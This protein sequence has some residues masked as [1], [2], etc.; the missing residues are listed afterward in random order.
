LAKARGIPV[1]NHYSSQKIKRNQSICREMTAKHAESLIE[2]HFSL[3]IIEL[4]SL[5]YVWQMNI[6]QAAGVVCSAGSP[7]LRN[8]LFA[9]WFCVWASKGTRQYQLIG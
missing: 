1:E 8:Q 4:N 6:V 3:K 9:G 2:N 5:K 7:N